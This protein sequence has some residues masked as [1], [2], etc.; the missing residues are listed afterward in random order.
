MKKLAIVVVLSAAF[1]V[2]AQSQND[3]L[4]LV[5]DQRWAND[6]AQAKKSQKKAKQKT[7]QQRVA[8]QARQGAGKPCAA[9]YWGGCLGWDPDPMVRFAIQH[10][11]NIFDD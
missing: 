4:S 2:P 6:F 1:L 7:A 9:R 10:D 3:S 11:S 5:Q 8:K